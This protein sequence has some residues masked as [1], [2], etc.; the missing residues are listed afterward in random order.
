M[1]GFSVECASAQDLQQAASAALVP[2]RVTAPDTA[3]F[4]ASVVAVR[5]GRVAVAR[6]RSEPH[7]VCR[8]A[9]W[10]TSTDPELVKVTWHRRGSWTVAQGERQSR[11]R[12]GQLVVFDTTRP[13]SIRVT[14]R[15]DVVAASVPRA[16]LGRHADRLRHHIAAPLAGDDGMRA[17]LA[18]LLCGI[19]DHAD[20]L[21][22]AIRPRLGD[23]LATLL[24]GTLTD[25]PARR[26]DVTVELL[27]Q[28]VVHVLANL[29]DPDLS[30]TSVARRHGISPRYL[31]RLFQRHERGFAAWVRHERLRRIR[32]DLLDPTLAG[33]TTAAIAA[34][35]GLLD[36]RHLGRALRAEFGAT[37]EE[38]RRSAVRSR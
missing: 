30:V 15:C 10:I 7:E 33:R 36:H 5:A 35:W 31:H 23:A 3:P 32:R 34:R 14:E 20:E 29:G 2:L 4:W 25:E 37:A 13:Y 6:V 26:T 8:P 17:V 27:D 38:L 16:M 22:G 1:S 11:V 28:I 18:A 12:A 24:A 19:G 9:E 21:T